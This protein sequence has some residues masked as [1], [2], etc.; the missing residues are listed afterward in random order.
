[1]KIFLCVGAV[2]NHFRIHTKY[3][4]SCNICKKTFARKRNRN[5]HMRLHTGERPFICNICN[6][7]FTQK[8]CLKE[9]INSKH[10]A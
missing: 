7:G 10:N 8:H 9:H 1:M 5:E 3:G 4:F 2:V 6:R